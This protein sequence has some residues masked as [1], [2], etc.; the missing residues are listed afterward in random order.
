V[1]VDSS[2][3][4]VRTKSGKIED[5]DF[6]LSFWLWENWQLSVEKYGRFINLLVVF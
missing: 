2:K 3:P 6:P 1:P 5:A 4:A